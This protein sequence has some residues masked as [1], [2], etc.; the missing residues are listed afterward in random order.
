MAVQIDLSQV[1]ANLSPRRVTVALIAALFLGCCSL[2]F[3]PA[4]AAPRAAPVNEE[5][6]A[7]PLPLRRVLIPEERVP[8]VLEKVQQGVLRQLPYDDLRTK[9]RAASRGARAIQKAPRLVKAH[10]SATL[11]GTALD[12][13]GFWTVT[14][15]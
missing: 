10:Y 14:N 4:F 8:A 11:R 15:A 6:E 12:G 1:K 9:L 13:N 7:D 2:L 5:E 3:V